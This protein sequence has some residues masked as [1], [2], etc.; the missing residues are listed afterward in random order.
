M[1]QRFTTNLNPDWTGKSQA[2]LATKQRVK[3][4]IRLENALIEVLLNQY[5]P[6]NPVE[7]EEWLRRG[8]NTTLP[9]IRG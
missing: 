9:V 3:D 8:I 5:I 7:R 6:L 2:S 1:R 4:A